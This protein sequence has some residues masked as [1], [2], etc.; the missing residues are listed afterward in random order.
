M[1]KKSSRMNIPSHNR[2]EDLKT[3]VPQRNDNVVVF[4]YPDRLSP[5]QQFDAAVAIIT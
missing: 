4:T 2:L 5:Q 1:L 3:H